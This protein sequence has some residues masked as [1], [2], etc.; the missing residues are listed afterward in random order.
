MSQRVILE[1]EDLNVSLPLDY[2]TL[3]MNATF[4][5]LSSQA[6]VDIDE[7]E[8]YNDAFFAI[9][10]YAIT[11]GK[12]FEGMKAKL[13]FEQSGQQ[14][15]ALEG[16]LDC[17]SMIE[18]APDF[19][20]DEHPV[21]GTVKF[22]KRDGRDALRDK[23]YGTSYTYLESEGVFTNNDYTDL[24][25]VIED[26]FDIIGFA[27]SIWVLFSLIDKIGE[28]IQAI[29]KTV[30]DIIAH[31]T[32]GQ[33]G[34]IAALVYSVVV[35]LLQLAYFGLL[36]AIL[37]NTVVDI[38]TTL[39]SPVYQHKMQSLQ[40]LI[41][42][43][44]AEFGYEFDSNLDILNDVYYLPNNPYD[45]STNLIQ[46]LLPFPSLVEKGIP[47]TGAFGWL[48]GQ[49]IEIAL[50][51]TGS[52][53]NVIGNTVY[54]RNVDDPFFENESNYTLPAVRRPTKQYNAND[55]KGTMTFEFL[56]DP[57]D[58]WTTRNFTGTT[59]EIKTVVETEKGI[60]YDLI[61]D[62]DRDIVQCALVNRKDELNIVEQVLSEI[63]GVADDLAN[64]IGGNTNFQS[65]LTDKIGTAKFTTAN[66]S[67]PRLV[68]LKGRR[69]PENHREVLAAKPLFETYKEHK[70]FVSGDFR[71]QKSLYL[72][73]DKVPMDLNDFNKLL[74]NQSF[75]D[76]KGKKAKALNIRY[77]F[78]RNYANVDYE[79][80]EV[81]SKRLKEIR[82][83]A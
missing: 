32:G 73:V 65:I 29:S 27:L 76:F 53:I 40:S 42:K 71:N 14:V 23:I 2:Q 37:I 28:L 33:T 82:I 16:Y 38:L 63:A 75:T 7:I 56:T 20:S 6:S 35:L 10:E 72:G 48:V 67:I 18:E 17:R 81:Y 79:I 44:L 64:L 50:K 25:F 74:Y 46:D 24:D 31:L 59:Y 36:L 39:S 68:Y 4:E 60:E 30:A 43:A 45:N 69:I 15:T 47:H 19:G 5:G 1:L 34:S 26:D 21:Q 80:R 58:A 61:G 62:F 78:P 3:E 55:V 11:N 66:I 57:V 77:V 8:V 41:S 52:E 22:V 12:I 54:M 83:E 13:R 51:I 9:K 70:S 49:M